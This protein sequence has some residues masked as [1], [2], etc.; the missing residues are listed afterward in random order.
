MAALT[1]LSTT[2]AFAMSPFPFFR[3]VRQVGV[4][5]ALD[6]S[7][8]QP[9]T[10]LDQ[11]GLCAFAAAELAHLIGA[12]GPPVLQLVR[13]DERIADPG[14]LVVLLHGTLRGETDALLALSAGLHRAGRDVGEPP[15]FIAPPQAVV[16]SGTTLPP[17][18]LGDALRR[19]LEGVARALLANR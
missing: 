19:L 8:P 14:T 18:A 12:G 11:D 5:C 13:N 6:G 7:S 10:L 9:T 4:L 17:E 3:E 15:F 2:G 1:I 16:A